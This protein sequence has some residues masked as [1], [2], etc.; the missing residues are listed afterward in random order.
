[1]TADAITLRIGGPEDFEALGALMF[2]AVR[3]GPSP[4]SEGQ[5]AAWVPELR[6]GAEWDAR[7]RPQHAVL[8]EDT[9]GRL[10][11]FMTLA[12]GGYI[13]FAYI[14]PAA[15]GMGLFRRMFDAVAQEARRQG[16]SRLW[17][18]ASLMA[19]PAF[20]AMGFTV[21]RREQVTIGA[22]TLDRCEMAM[23]I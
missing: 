8:A 12:G 6:K 17:V 16:V 13:D 22:E 11:G 21:V 7:L 20:A 3:T 9:A 19:E 2:D 18:H 10:L 4:Y 5:R 23:G 14:A 1:M 15:R